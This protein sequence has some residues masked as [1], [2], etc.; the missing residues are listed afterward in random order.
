MHAFSILAATAALMT[1]ALAD[2][3]LYASQI[4]LNIEPTDTDGFLFLA[5][6]PSCDDVFN[7]VQR[8]GSDDVSGDKHGVRCNDCGS[9]TGTIDDPDSVS[10]T[11]VEWNDEDYGHYT[12]YADRDGAIVDLDGNVVGHCHT[13]TSDS[14]TCSDVSSTFRGWSQIFCETDLAIP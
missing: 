10:P 2:F 13:D 7:A 4:H 3:Y 6:P 14:Y 1:P 9:A 11:L 8:T 12:Y 5:G